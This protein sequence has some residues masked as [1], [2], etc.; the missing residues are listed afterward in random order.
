MDRNVRLTGAPAG[1]TL[2]GRL[3]DGDETLP[4]IVT[5]GPILDA[6]GL[7]LA[8]Y[9]ASFDDAD[10]AF[11]VQLEWLQAGVPQPVSFDIIEAAGVA[12]PFPVSLT[13]AGLKRRL[14][15]ELDADD[16][17]LT[18]YLAAAVMQAQAPWPVGC[19]RLLFPDP[20]DPDDLVV[21]RTVTVRRG[22]AL[23]PDASTLSTVTVDGTLV[24]Q[25]G[26]RTY[27]RDG[28]IV[29]LRGL[30]YPDPY[31]PVAP[32]DES[33]C[34]VT[35]RF[36]FTSIPANLADAIYVLAGRYVYEEAVL[37]ADRIEVLEGTAVQSYYRQLPVRT[38][39]V[40]QTYAV[41]N[42]VVGLA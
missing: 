17:K 26:Y 34:V 42:A 14:D 7:P 33:Q 30:D 4:T 5:V 16:D 38:K 25:S 27:E 9:E 10:L 21:S 20:P 3:V 41:P 18:D 8:G 24:G 13:L 35:G 39:L 2:T 23:V 1:L 28:Y 31:R 29:Q 12:T 15:R 36:G 40:F 19:G 6:D 11:P 22:R 37:F 32:V